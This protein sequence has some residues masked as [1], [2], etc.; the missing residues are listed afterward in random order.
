[1]KPI[2]EL[3][4]CCCGEYTMGRQWWNRDKGFGLCVRCADMISQKEDSETMN[5]CYGERGVHYD[6]EKSEQV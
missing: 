1:M 3:V 6:V 2:K 4:C 5:S